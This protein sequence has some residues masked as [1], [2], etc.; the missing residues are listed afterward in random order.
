MGPSTE[1]TNRNSI[2]PPA[3]SSAPALA[4]APGLGAVPAPEPREAPPA[5]VGPRRTR[6]SVRSVRFDAAY[7]YGRGLSARQLAEQLTDSWAARGVNVVYFYAYNR[8]YGARYTT[9]YPGNIM[10]D[11]GRQDLLGHMLRAAHARGIKVIAWF[12][13]VQHKQAWDAHPDWRERTRDGAD[14]RPDADSY[15]L[16][17]RNPEVMG[18]W[19][20]F[21][22]DL[23]T[24][25]PDLDGIDMAESQ[26]DLWGDHACYCDHCRA[27]FAQ[28]RPHDEPGGPAWRSF[29]AAGLTQA[30]LATTRFAH[31]R[32]LESHVTSTF[33]ARRDGSLMPS[34]EIRD[35]TGFDLDALL[36]SADR[37]DVIQAELIWQQWAAAYGDRKTFSPDWTYRAVREAKRMVGGRSALICH[38]EVTDFGSGSLDGRGL[39]LTVAAAMRGEPDGI[40]IYG[41]HLLERTEGATR[42]LQ[43]AWLDLEH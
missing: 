35:A 17:V 16:C 43:T 27:Q 11:Y 3:V 20:G 18:W 29:R 30:L 40:D 32:G 22:D 8:V 13:G 33:T 39:G 12:Y 36:A 25:Y 19:L 23:L 2:P 38:L 9:H 5:S 1:V 7:Y 4:P 26:V 41:A 42:Y 34:R 21:L 28:E 10:E 15:F 37:P 6:E 14:Y 24:H 31:R